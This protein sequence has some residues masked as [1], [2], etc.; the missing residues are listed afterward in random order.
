MS[1]GTYALTTLAAVNSYL[2]ITADGGD[3]DAFIEDLID[4]VTAQCEQYTGRKL[5]ARDYHYDSA[6]SDYDPD[7]A[8]LDG[9]GE[10]YL[11]TPQW[12]INSVS[13]LTIGDTT[14]T[15]RESWD[16]TGYVIYKDQGRIYL[17]GYT[18]TEGIKNIFLAYNAGYTTI[19]E[20]LEQS[21]IQQVAMA[22]KESD[23]GHGRLGVRVQDTSDGMTTRFEAGPIIPQV[24][25]VWDRYRQLVMA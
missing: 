18:F 14:I 21:V 23:Q 24:Q 5:K 3:R 16:E 6:D 19:P 20:D 25:A 15:E 8:I 1:V 17:A 22:Y 10:Q 9:N 13:I 7:N 11:F 2:K 4:R 12:P